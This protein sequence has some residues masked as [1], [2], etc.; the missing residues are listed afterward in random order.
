MTGV[1]AAASWFRLAEMTGAQLDL[2]VETA[3]KELRDQQLAGWEQDA[4]LRLLDRIEAVR[5]MF[6]SAS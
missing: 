6:A 3:S 1:S 4:R 5:E 2:L